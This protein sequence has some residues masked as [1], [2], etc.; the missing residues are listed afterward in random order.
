V[1]LAIGL[2]HAQTLNYENYRKMMTGLLFAE[3]F[4]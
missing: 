4:D 2:G 3:F 1:G